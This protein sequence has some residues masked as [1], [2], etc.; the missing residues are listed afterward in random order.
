MP[1]VKFALVPRVMS[2]G[3]FVDPAEP[4]AA[5]VIPI[6]RPLDL[7]NDPLLA[8]VL[9]PTVVQRL[10]VVAGP[11][12]LRRDIRPVQVV[13]PVLSFDRQSASTSERRCE[14]KD[15]QP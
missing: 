11:R 6:E 8:G 1:L 14:K 9:I 3:V 5:I 13:G 12:C 15:F 4:L 2:F 10:V 7:R